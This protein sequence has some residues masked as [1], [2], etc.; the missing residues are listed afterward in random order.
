MQGNNDLWNKVLTEI[1]LDVS[2]A[3]FL[4]LFKRTRLIA[5]EDNVLTIAAPS[6][7][8]IDLLQ[9]R[10][11]DVIKKSTD[12]HTK[13]NTKLIYS[14]LCLSCLLTLHFMVFSL[15]FGQMFIVLFSDQV[16]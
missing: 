8:I 2:R 15:R 1:E 12:K 3:N 9:R 5:L 6:A 11:Y 13:K 16:F 7:M 4:T 14:F 10:F